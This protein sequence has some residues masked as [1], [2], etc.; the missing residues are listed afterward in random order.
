MGTTGSSRT[1]GGPLPGFNGKGRA[2]RFNGRNSRVI[3]RN[4]RSL[5]PRSRNIKITVHV[6]F[7]AKPSASVADYDLVRKQS[8]GGTYKVEIRR[9]GQAFCKFRGTYGNVAITAGPDLSDG[10]WHT[11]VCEKASST[12]TLTV[13]GEPVRAE[14][15][16]RVDLQHQGAGPRRQ[17][18]TGRLVQGHH[19]RGP[20]R[21]RLGHRTR[22]PSM[23]TH[24]VRR[25]IGVAV[26][27]LT[28][29]GWCSA[30][31][32]AGVPF[33]EGRHDLDGRQ[34]GPVGHLRR[35]VRVGRRRVRR[36][37]PTEREQ[38]ACRPG[39]TA[40]HPRTGDP[41]RVTMPRL[42][43]NP[44]VNDMS[45]GPGGVLYLAGEFTYAVGGRSGKNFGR[46]RPRRPERSSV[47]SPHRSS[48]PCSRRRNASTPQQENGCRRTDPTGRPMPGSAPWSSGS[49]IRCEPTRR[50]SRSATC[51]R[52]AVT[53]SSSASSTTST[54]RRRRSR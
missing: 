44:V 38:R 22:R 50:R 28:M 18:D 47:T 39:F 3:V 6:K 35:R 8:G 52:T 2:Y 42:R 32:L 10:R 24:T 7:S 29:L 21:L 15:R 51:W 13:D 11:I 12:V 17:G 1:S 5:N 53:S 37:A 30:V 46:H 41:A 49:T 36:R 14:R 23:E 45:L 40:L 26:A 27:T 16:H 20:H 19:G 25:W 9:S 43:S 54:A 33:S 4:D 48:G 31:A 34:R